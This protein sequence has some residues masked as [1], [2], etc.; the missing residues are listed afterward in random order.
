MPRYIKQK[1][2]SPLSIDEGVELNKKNVI[3]INKETFNVEISIFVKSIKES[4]HQ[5]SRLKRIC[6][7]ILYDTSKHKKNKFVQIVDRIHMFDDDFSG[8]VDNTYLGS[9]IA[10]SIDYG[11]IN[12]ILGK[13]KQECD[14]K[15]LGKLTYPNFQKA[16]NNLPLEFEP[17]HILIPIKYYQDIHLIDENDFICYENSTLKLNINDKKIEVMWS[18]NY[19]D[20]KEI[21]LI[22]KNALTWISKKNSE[23]KKIEAYKNYTNLDMDIDTISTIYG[24]Y[25][26]DKLDF[27]TRVIGAIKLNKKKIKRY[28]IS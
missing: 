18:N 11:K 26:E 7:Q 13:I 6:E 9:Q 12:Y 24:R 16:I 8:K 1:D 4:Y 28:S 15:I 10:D 2:K 27:V 23:M 19:M 17:T 21:Y 3:P 5:R 25:K 14:K 20:F 22:G